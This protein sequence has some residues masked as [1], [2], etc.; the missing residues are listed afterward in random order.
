MENYHPN[1]YPELPRDG[2][3]ETFRLD[4][5]VMLYKN[6]KMKLNIMRQFARNISGITI[7]FLKF[8]YQQGQFLLSRVRL[9]LGPLFSV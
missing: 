8:L 7:F 1:V 4:K 2:N 3:D 6:S 9:V 5:L